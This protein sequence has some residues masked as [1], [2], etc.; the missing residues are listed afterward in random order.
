MV[1]VVIRLFIDGPIGKSKLLFASPS[2][3]IDLNF[4][5]TNNLFVIGPMLT[6]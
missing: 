5:L 6:G 3:N 2:Q 4:G 1:K